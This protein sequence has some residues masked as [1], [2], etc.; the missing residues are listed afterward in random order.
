MKIIAFI[1][2]A[3]ARSFIK[4]IKAHNGRKG[5]ECCIVVGESINRR[6]ILK[7]KTSTKA[8][9]NLSFRQQRDKAHHKGISPLLEL[10]S[11]DMIKAFYIH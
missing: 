5:C 8:K 11:L 10:N 2:D 1:C 3:P 4:C 6:M 7:M 9:T